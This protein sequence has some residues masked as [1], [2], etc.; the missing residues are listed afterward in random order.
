[1]PEAG[2]EITIPAN[3]RPQSHALDCAVTSNRILLTKILV[4]NTFFLKVFSTG[5]K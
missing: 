2:L 4:Y 1:M 3:Q 5:I